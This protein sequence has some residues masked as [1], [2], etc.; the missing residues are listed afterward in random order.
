M[1]DD[2]DLVAFGCHGLVYHQLNDIVCNDLHIESSIC[3]LVV[4][5]ESTERGYEHIL[6][7]FTALAVLVRPGQWSIREV[8]KKEESGLSPR[9]I[10]SVEIALIEL[11]FLFLW[12]RN[13][14]RNHRTC[15]TEFHIIW[16]VPTAFVRLA[17]LIA[18]RTTCHLFYLEIGVENSAVEHN[19]PEH[20]E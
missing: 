12:V 20:T 18:T 9:S 3:M 2:V 8:V 16:R 15:I 10:P 7:R 1:T 13:E 6:P 4:F 19:G 11:E 17:N 14:I 5:G